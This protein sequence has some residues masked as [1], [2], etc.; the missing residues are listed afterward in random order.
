MQ[1]FIGGEVYEEEDDNEK[2]LINVQIE[3]NGERGIVLNPQK[4]TTM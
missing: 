4:A 2:I 3:Q 1:S